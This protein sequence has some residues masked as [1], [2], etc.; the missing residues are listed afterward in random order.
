M[1]IKV[2][3][4]TNSSSEV[5]GVVAGDSAAVAGLIGV[6]LDLFKGCKM[7]NGD[8]GGE[9]IQTDGIVADSTEAAEQIAQAAFEDAKRQEEIIKGA[10]QEAGDTLD[11]AKKA[12]EKELDECKK[13]WE[14]SE[15]TADKSD[16]GYEKLKGQYDD[17]MDYLDSQIKKTDYQ[18]QMI[19]YEKAVK[20]AEMDS[21]NEW[22]DQQK[23][24][25]IAVKE[26][27]AMLEAVQK[28]YDRPGYNTDAVNI[29]LE[30]LKA[31]EKELSDTLSKNNASFEYTA[32]DRGTIGP[33]KESQ[34]LTNKIAAEKESFEKAKK[35]ADSKR[36]KELEADME[37]NM[38]E[39][40][41]QIKK[42]NM[43][44]IATKAAEGTQ[45]GADIAIEGLSF[46]TGP[47]GQKIK[48]AYT[49]GK[50]IASGMGEGMADPKNASK[51]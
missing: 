47:A 36:R 20:Q 19:D 44:D 4:V 40:K 37:K 34:E 51:H 9:N 29:R 49:A 39:Y 21:K 22:V 38:E 30:Q 12:L 35:E 23:K 46:V 18:K 17:Y 3:Y 31:R 50:N 32:R 41:A 33:S 10:Y 24:D 16:P 13:A 43:Y 2:D 5:F 45:F 25:Y 8:T 11:S 7:T 26:E 28:G 42:A 1:K 48:L 14:E 15:K 6:I 27:K